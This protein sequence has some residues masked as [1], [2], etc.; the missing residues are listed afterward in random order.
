MEKK[1]KDKRGGVNDDIFLWKYCAFQM[2][3]IKT[4]D[5]TN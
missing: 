5:G 2:S 1:E 4:I 3:T